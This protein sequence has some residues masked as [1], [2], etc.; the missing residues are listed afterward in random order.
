MLAFSLKYS[1]GNFRNYAAHVSLNTEATHAFVTRYKYVVNVSKFRAKEEHA[2]SGTC[3][4]R[5]TEKKPLHCTSGKIF[6]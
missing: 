3:L 1:P 4:Y 5:L 2:S 6:S